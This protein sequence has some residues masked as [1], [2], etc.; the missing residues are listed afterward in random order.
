M[1]PFLILSGIGMMLVGIIPVLYWKAKKGLGIRFFAGGAFIWIMAIILKLVMDFTITGAINQW[2]LGETGI[3]GVLI[4]SGAIVGI[5]TG[6]LEN[7]LQYL[8]VRKYRPL[9]NMNFGEGIAFGLGFGC[10]EAFSIGL[11]NF[12]TMASLIMFPG[13]IPAQ[14]AE[15]LKAPTIIA[16]APII[17]RVFVVL[18]H[19]FTSIL[20]IYSIKSNRI[21]YFI[22]AFFYKTLLDGIIPYLTN[23][24]NQTDPSSVFAVEIPVVIM[25]L[26]GLWGIQ[27]L[28]KKFEKPEVDKK[29]NGKRKILLVSCSVIT[30][31]LI[32]VVLFLLVP[33][34]QNTQTPVTVEPDI[35]S[36]IGEYSFF[37]GGQYAGFSSYNISELT[38]YNGK[39]AYILSE[40]AELNV[41]GSKQEIDGTLYL[42]ASGLPLYYYS[43]IIVNGMENEIEVNFYDEKTVENVVKLGKETSLDL[44]ANE[45]AYIAANNMIGH[46]YILFRS[47]EM[48]EGKTYTVNIF[49]PNVAKFIPLMMKKTDL[50]EEIAVQGRK[51]NATK[52]IDSIGQTHYL[53][54]DGRLLKIVQGGV[55]MILN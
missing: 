22:Y 2:F 28:R 1:N 29:E 46:W 7:G 33:N 34:P 42:S 50:K 55:E 16:L 19:V 43:K 18:A 52:V 21:I 47:I 31:I 41:D 49:S 54:D 14:A 3:I 44:P 17:E 48:T 35:A 27:M 36:E 38:T 51:V 9:G 26:I 24:L 4:F 39:E 40:K 25:G 13:M 12:I 32:S 30:V 11:I 5:R 23:G 45:N 15:A 6:L 37:I 20:V 53:S 8:G 10:F